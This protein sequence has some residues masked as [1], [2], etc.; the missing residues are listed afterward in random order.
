MPDDAP[1]T[2]HTELCSLVWELRVQ[3]DVPL[4]PGA[5]FSQ[6]AGALSWQDFALLTLKSGTFGI[7]IAIVT[8]FH[9]LARPLRLEEV[10]NA[11]TRAVVQ[12]IVLITLLDALFIVVYLFM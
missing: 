6:L 3:V 9:G 11:T 1:P 4:R 5:Y 7:I 2:V 10:A 8:C 12:S